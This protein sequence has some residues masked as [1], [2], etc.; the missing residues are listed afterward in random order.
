MSGYAK[1]WTDSYDDK[2]FVELSALDR[3]I[4]WQLIVLAKRN[5][6]TGRLTYRT[7]NGLADILGADRKTTG[8][9]LRY[10]HDSEHIKLT[11][12]KKSIIIEIANYH[13][14]QELNAKEHLQK[15]GK[16]VEKSTENPLLPEQTIPHQNTPD[17]SDPAR[18]LVNPIVEQFNSRCRDLP[19]VKLIAPN[20]TRYKHLLTRIKEDKERLELTWW[21]ALFDKIAASEYLCGKVKDW[22]AT[23]DWIVKAENFIKILEG[24]Y[25]RAGKQQFTHGPNDYVPGYK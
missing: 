19:T 2:W 24:N 1:I 15:R 7:W 22:R 16:T 6:D 13:Y 4:F 25:D 21:N 5:G 17:Q 23:F 12:E 3:G 18:D 10:F 14:W 20:S 9:S 8:K 11:E